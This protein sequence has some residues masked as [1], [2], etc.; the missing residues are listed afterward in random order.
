VRDQNEIVQSYHG[1]LPRA[2]A[3][4]TDAAILT[5]RCSIAARR[6]LSEPPRSK[7]PSCHNAAAAAYG[8]RGTGTVL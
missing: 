7:V 4:A 8:S 2:V 6:R 5:E 3:S 1:E